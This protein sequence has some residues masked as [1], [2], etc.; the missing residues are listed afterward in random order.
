MQIKA[1]SGWTWCDDTGASITP[2][3]ALSWDDYVAY[4]SDAK[5]FHNKGW[6]HLEKFSTLMPLLAIGANMFHSTVP[7]VA[8]TQPLVAS[9]LPP[10]PPS[11]PTS[12]NSSPADSSQSPNPAL[13]KS[14]VP[15]A[16]DDT[17]I[18]D[19]EWEVSNILLYW[20]LYFLHVSDCSSPSLRPKAPRD[21]QS[22]SPPVSKRP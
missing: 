16:T 12:A 17:E 2:D 10:G 11:Q 22:M 20:L 14:N 4:H 21:A 3:T 1:V 8:P 6:A 15:D 7:P 18:S 19:N 5:P 13:A 9:S